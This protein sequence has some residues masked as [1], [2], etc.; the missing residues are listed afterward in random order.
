MAFLFYNPLRWKIGLAEIGIFQGWRNKKSLV[1]ALMLIG[2][3]TARSHCQSHQ[4]ASLTDCVGFLERTNLRLNETWTGS[5]CEFQLF[6][7]FQNL[8]AERRRKPHASEG[9][10]EQ[11]SSA[12]SQWIR[13]ITY[14][15]SCRRGHH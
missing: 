2:K 1:F 8:S 7:R 5:S 6:M 14:D 12:C 4:Y 9:Y 10:L 15:V 11:F 3:G 13:S